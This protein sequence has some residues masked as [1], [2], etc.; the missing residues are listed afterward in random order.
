MIIQNGLKTYRKISHPTKRLIGKKNYKNE[1]KKT[2][3]S[4]KSSSEMSA[5][6]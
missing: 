5:A 6:M 1:K 3:T 4:S 2:F